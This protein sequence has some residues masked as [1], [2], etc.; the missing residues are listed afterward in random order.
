MD[1]IYDDGGQKNLVPIKLQCLLSNLTHGKAP[2]Y[3]ALIIH[4]SF[5]FRQRLAA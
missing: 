1:V 5:H 2:S 4:A 3:T